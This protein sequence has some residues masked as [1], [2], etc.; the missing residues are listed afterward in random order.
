MPTRA[1]V[2]PA[3]LRW[4]RESIGFEIDEAANRVGVKPE[5][6]EQAERGEWQL[7]LRQAEEAARLYQRLFAALF[8]PFSSPRGSRTRTSAPTL[9]GPQA[10]L[11]AERPDGTAV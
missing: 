1:Y 2:T 6:L 10:G 11:R 8:V 7:T 3:A 9:V 5:R 4:A